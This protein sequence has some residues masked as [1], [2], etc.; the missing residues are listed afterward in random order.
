[1]KMCSRLSNNLTLRGV[2]LETKQSRVS[3]HPENGSVMNIIST[4]GGNGSFSMI[5]KLHCITDLLDMH[6]KLLHS[7]KG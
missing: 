7:S 4:K 3:L 1:M 6:T 2:L 5:I